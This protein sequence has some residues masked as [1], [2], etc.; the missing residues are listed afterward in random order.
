MRTAVSENLTFQEINKLSSFE[1]RLEQKEA[2]LS[3]EERSAEKEK[4]LEK[5][6]F[7]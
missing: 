5:R 2:K 4:S 6:E 7:I 1:K 3:P